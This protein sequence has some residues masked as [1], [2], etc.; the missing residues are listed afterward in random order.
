MK[1]IY[2]GF[3]FVKLYPPLCACSENPFLLWVIMTYYEHKSQNSII[4]SIM[5]SIQYHTFLHSDI[6]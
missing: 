5:L 6:I 4:P 3:S 1:L 2:L